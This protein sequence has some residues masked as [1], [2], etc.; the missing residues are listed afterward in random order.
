[1]PFDRLVTLIGEAEPVPVKLPGDDVT[2]YPVI[3]LPPLLA[4]AVNATDADALPAVAVTPVGDPGAV[5][6]ALA[7]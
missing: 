4:G 6:D 2:V 1:M 7:V 3:A 5:A